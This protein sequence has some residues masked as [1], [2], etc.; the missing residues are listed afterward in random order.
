M[1]RRAPVSLMGGTLVLVVGVTAPGAGLAGHW[2]S[3]K[4]SNTLE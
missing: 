1:V 4:V 3:N 2:Y